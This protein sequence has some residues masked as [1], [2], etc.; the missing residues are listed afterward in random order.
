[1]EVTPNINVCPI[2]L[3]H[4]GTLPKINKGAIDAALKTGLALNCVINRF[5]KFDRKNYFYPDLP[6]AY[7]ISQY[8]QPLCVNGYLA[9][10]LSGKRI[11]IR[12]I[13]L[14]EDAGKLYHAIDGKH[15]LADFNRAG[16][17]LM[18]LVTEPDFS[19]AGDAVEFAQE[20]QLILRYLEVSDGDMEKGHLR[21]EANISI[22]RDGAG[23]LGTKV[24]VKNLNSFKAVSGAIAYELDRQEKEIEKGG[25]IT[26]ETRGWDEIKQKTTSQRSKEE[27]HDYRY[28]PEPDLPPLTFTDEY[29]EAIKTQIPEL[30]RQRRERFVYEY[31]LSN[32]QTEILI[33][34]L[35]L[36]D[37]YEEAVSELKELVPQGNPEMVYN[38]LASDVKGIETERRMLLLESK[39]T[40]ENLAQIV[41]FII[42]GK[43]SSRVAKDVLL[44]SFNNGA[45]PENIIRQKGLLQESDE[46]VLEA[47]VKEVVDRN[48]KVWYDYKNGKENA[49]QFLVGQVIAKTRGKAN[50]EVVKNIFRRLS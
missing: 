30:P 9:L 12:R 28:F 36:S 48:N 17:P 41:A 4:P 33:R 24:E 45:N 29:I 5:S 42:Q 13:H 22:A 11:R 32:V 38:Y 39:L 49:L 10:P 21:I 25:K 8:D 26:Q 37:F 35:S 7:Q 43:I 3:G 40:P 47:V 1:M 27:A 46:S 19:S 20:F 6:K 50:P 16:I 31:N 34:S 14:E 2:C 23:E 18:E 44:E 15:S